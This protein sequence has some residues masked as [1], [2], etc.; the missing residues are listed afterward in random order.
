LLFGAFKLNLKIID[1]PIRYQERVYG[2]TNI[3]RFRHGLLLIKMWF[4]ALFKI[5][6]R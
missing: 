5:K 1:M 3:S 6:F 4:F 2:D